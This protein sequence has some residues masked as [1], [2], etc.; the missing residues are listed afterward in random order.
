MSVVLGQFSHCFRCVWSGCSCHIQQASNQWL[1][2]FWLHWLADSIITT[3]FYV[4]V[5]RGGGCF[6]VQHMELVKY[7]LNGVFLMNT[8]L[9]LISFYRYAK[10][11]LYFSKV[12]HLEGC[13]QGGLDLCQLYFAV[14]EYD[15]VINKDSYYCLQY[16]LHI[17]QHVYCNE[18]LLC[19]Q[20]YHVIICTSAITCTVLCIN[21]YIII[22]PLTDPLLAS[23]LSTFSNPCSRFEAT[24]CFD[25]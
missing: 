14:T 13:W 9:I 25:H 24:S 11:V 8:Q 19:D 16:I 12:L 7:L 4:S 1:I 6:A 17:P 20:T 5:H 22:P 23:Q 3:K 2:V 21:T 18:L 15:Q 10:T